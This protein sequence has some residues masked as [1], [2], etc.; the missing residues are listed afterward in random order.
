MS[1]LERDWPDPDRRDAA[2][3]RCLERTYRSQH[4]V[5]PTPSQLRVLAALSHGVDQRGAAELLGIT[6]ETVKTQLRDA[7]RRLGCKTTAHAVAEALRRD[8]IL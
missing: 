6:F 4:L 7:K 5:Q 1:A 2:L 3:L 8:L